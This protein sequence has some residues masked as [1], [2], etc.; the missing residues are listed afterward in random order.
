MADEIDTSTEAVVRAIARLAQTPMDMGPVEWD[1][2]SGCFFA[3][4]AERDRLREELNAARGVND[5]TRK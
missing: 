1:G 4:A 5:E 3:L 2:I